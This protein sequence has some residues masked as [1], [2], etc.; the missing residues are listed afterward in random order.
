[1]TPTAQAGPSARSLNQPAGG[2]PTGSTPTPVLAQSVA[3]RPVSGTVTVERPG[4]PHFVT[5]SKSAL[6]PVGSL[7]NVTHGR[8][9]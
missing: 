1:M 6:I 3:G 5:L 4:T 8:V 7:V 9:S 2:A